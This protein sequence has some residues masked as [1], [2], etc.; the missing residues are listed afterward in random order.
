MTDQELT[1]LRHDLRRSFIITF[2][3]CLLLVGI[4]LVTRYTH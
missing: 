4:F 1:Y 3:L 2:L